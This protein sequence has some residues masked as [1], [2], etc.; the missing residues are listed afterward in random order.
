[1]L[2]L[3]VL[4]ATSPTLLADRDPGSLLIDNFDGG[5]PKLGRSWETYKDDN[6]L[7]TKVNP[8]AVEKGGSPKGFKGHGHFS[9]HVGKNKDPWPWVVLDLSLQ[10]DGPKDLSGYKAV[11]FWVKGDGKKHRVRIGRAA[12]EDYCYPEATFVA[13]KEWALVTLPLSDF[14]QPAWGKQVPAGFKDVNRIG[15][16]ALANGDDE[17]FEL[18]FTGLEFVKELP[19]QGK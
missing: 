13:P 6:D 9:G 14:K 17:D 11:R 15:F 1:M 4:T 16:V 5:G 3:A 10:E 2:T 18:R 19:G 8:F 7:G 12:V